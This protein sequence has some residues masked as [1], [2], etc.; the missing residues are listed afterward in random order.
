MSDVKFK[1]EVLPSENLTYLYA[2]SFPDSYLGAPICYKT[3][4][5]A[6]DAIVRQYQQLLCYLVSEDDSNPVSVR[7]I[8]ASS[9]FFSSCELFRIGT[10]DTVTGELVSDVHKISIV[11]SD[12]EPLFPLI[13]DRFIDNLSKR[14][15]VE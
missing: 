12:G 1:S 10:F 5:D 15:E 13:F 7:A 4:S 3:D 2:L 8:A 14:G 6:I 11:N 9:D